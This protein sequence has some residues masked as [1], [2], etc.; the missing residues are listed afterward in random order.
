MSIMSS[1][2]DKKCGFCDLESEVENELQ[3]SC[4]I[5]ERVIKLEALLQSVLKAVESVQSVSAN[6]FAS[7]TKLQLNAEA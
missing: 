1:T 4:K 5:S 6:I 3:I 2:I 7:V